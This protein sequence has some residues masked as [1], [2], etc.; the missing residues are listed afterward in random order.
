M[1]H[2]ADIDSKTPLSERPLLIP[3]K[4]YSD[5]YLSEPGKAMSPAVDEGYT[6]G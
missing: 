1:R 4:S 3:S 6:Q 5:P 2:A